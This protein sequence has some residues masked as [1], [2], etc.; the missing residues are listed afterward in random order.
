METTSV[1]H[2]LA[3]EEKGI[4]SRNGHSYGAGRRRRSSI[5]DSYTR[6]SRNARMRMDQASLDSC[7]WI[8]DGRSQNDHIEVHWVRVCQE[9]FP[10]SR[11]A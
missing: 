1:T 10:F 5:Q 7:F 11:R 9:D 3:S 4:H 2:T 6:P 8:Q